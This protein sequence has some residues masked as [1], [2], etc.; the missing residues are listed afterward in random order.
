MAPARPPETAKE[1]DRG[2]RRRG[3]L[4][5]AS[6]I[7]QRNDK[8]AVERKAD[9][10]GLPEDGASDNPTDDFNATAGADAAFFEDVRASAM[11]W[12]ARLANK[13][14]V[15]TTMLLSAVHTLAQSGKGRA[16]L[17][18]L[19]EAHKG[20]ARLR[21]TQKLEAVDAILGFPPPGA[22]IE[23]NCAKVAGGAM[24]E[25]VPGQTEGCS[26]LVEIVSQRD[27]GGERDAASGDSSKDE[28]SGESSDEHESAGVATALDEARIEAL[29]LKE[30]LGNAQNVKS[31]DVIDL[32][33]KLPQK[34][35]DRAEVSSWLTVHLSGKGR[36]RESQ[37]AA[38]IDAVLALV[39]TPLAPLCAPKQHEDLLSNARAKKAGSSTLGPESPLAELLAE[40]SSQED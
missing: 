23:D 33:Q 4:A 1:T 40:K 35:K 32:L 14:N 10:A 3:A 7:A 24:K 31:S 11:A 6:E 8:A 38:A 28:D 22:R 37:K 21:H 20:K 29:R 5:P 19:A 26:R 39:P 30:K 15:K 27:R 25:S 34:T 9:I 18:K 12:K 17:G 16:Q 36:L 13:Q 2:C